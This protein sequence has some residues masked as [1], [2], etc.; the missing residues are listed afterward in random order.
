VGAWHCPCR[1][2]TCCV[3][4]TLM[5]NKLRANWYAKQLQLPLGMAVESGNGNRN[6][7]E[8]VKCEAILPLIWYLY[9]NWKT[10]EFWDLAASGRN[11][12]DSSASQHK[13]HLSNC[14]SEVCFGN[15]QLKS[16]RL[17]SVCF[18]RI[19]VHLA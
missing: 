5:H 17:L 1:W 19:F 3:Y 11:P 7:N 13:A 4:A 6:G 2:E 8:N 9:Y 14:I 12:C 16:C 15:N 10:G 18:S